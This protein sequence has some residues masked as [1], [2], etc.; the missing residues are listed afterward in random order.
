M[1]KLLKPFLF[2][3]AFLVFLITVLLGYVKFMLPNIPETA[4]VKFEY[5]KERIER[6]RYLAHNVMMCID[7]HSQR[8]YSKF[9]APM[10]PGTTGAGG[11]VFGK[12]MGFPGTFRSPNI[13]PYY[14]ADWSDTELFRAIT[15]GVSKDGHALFPLMPYQ[16]F[17]KLDKEDI[18]SVIAYIRQLEPVKNDVAP[19][20]IDFPV[21]FIVNTMPAE[22]AFSTRPAKEELVAYGKYLFDAATCNDCHTPRVKG[23]PVPE[24]FLA[25]GA[26][27]P[28]PDNTILRS[29]NIT[30]DPETG[31]GKWTEEE[32][33][34]RFKKYT[35]ADYTPSSVEPGDFKTIMPWY[36]YANME[37]SDLKAI[38]AYLKTVPAINNR[39]EVFETVE[40]RGAQA[41]R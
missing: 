20:E 3:I 23:E 4:E 28:F 15:T 38:Y 18:Y 1:K 6:G 26:E 29:A 21:N 14:L 12:E 32:F 37:E 39:V 40:N 19:S 9:G 24:K 11:E 35:A 33:V 7:C 36:F 25:G 5:T 41:S 2:V 13:T 16:S 27:F 8:D 34:H 22:P 31:I 30:P 10:K 17:G